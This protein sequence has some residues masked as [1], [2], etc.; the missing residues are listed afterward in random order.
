LFPLTLAVGLAC[1]GPEPTPGAETGGAPTA[2][3]S[4]TA[5]ALQGVPS[6]G[7]VYRVKDI[8]PG[9]PGS[10]PSE[11]TDVD[12]T[13]FFSARDALHGTELWKS[14]GTP[15]GTR[16]VAD[17]RPGGGDSSP[18][19]LTAGGGRVYFI[20]D[21]GTHGL[22][23]WTSDGT[24]A[25]TRLVLDIQPGGESSYPSTLLAVDGVLYFVAST[26]GFEASQL[27]RTEGTPD[28][29]R[30][31]PTGLRY[32][33]FPVVAMDGRLFFFQHDG[34]A[35]YRLDGAT[36]DVVK[37]RDFSELPYDIF[38]VGPV[39]ADG[40]LYFIVGESPIIGLSPEKSTPGV[41]RRFTL[42]KSD[43]TP[44]GTVSVADVPAL[45][46]DTLVTAGR[47]LFFVA[48]DGAHGFEL[49]T[50]DGTRAGTVLVKD[51]LPG[52]GS[53]NLREPTVLGGV[54]YFSAYTPAVG[55]ELWRSDGTERGTFLV[56]DLKPGPSSSRI[57][58]LT[59][60]GGR[61][62]FSAHEWTRGHEPWT[63]DG[64]ARGTVR[65]ADLVPGVFSSSPQDFTRSGPRVFFAATEPHRGTEPWALRLGT[66]L[67]H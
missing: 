46:S 16:L 48:D 32:P 28:T 54:L 12:G 6:L 10:D 41:P 30:L 58:Q 19:E 64:T 14:D 61:L 20:A 33:P 8:V 31:V 49:W 17:I 11:L 67:T 21:D 57:A 38:T 7:A 56:K 52:P 39:A 59:A 45:V 9:R 43:G 29:T 2:A 23:L 66:G 4:R 1:G 44:E 50:S 27:W 47:R 25:G 62:F 37:L 22:E 60:Q 15:R 34:R 24:R 13:L 53:P 5:E 26:P 55:D 35:I 36:G 3:E 42:W 18:H 63:S 40:L 65:L 51:I